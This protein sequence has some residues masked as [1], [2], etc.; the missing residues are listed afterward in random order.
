RTESALH[1][2]LGPERVHKGLLFPAAQPLK[3]QNILSCGPPGGQNTGLYRLAVHH[4]GTGAACTLT[5][6]ILYGM[7]LQI[8]P[9]I[10]EQRFI[11]LRTPLFPVH[12]KTEILS[13]CIPSKNMSFLLKAVSS[14]RH[15]PSLF[16]HGDPAVLHHMPAPQKHLLHSG[17]CLPALKR[18]IIH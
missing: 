8:V 2:P 10:A 7:Q 6:S 12:C 16:F 3:R 14:S 1:S 15:I 4:N 17:R 18:C 9:E 5:A 13:H 11:L